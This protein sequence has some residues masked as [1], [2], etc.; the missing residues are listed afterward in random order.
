MTAHRIPR[1]DGRLGLC[2][3]SG[4]IKPILFYDH[5]R[6]FLPEFIAASVQKFG[7]SGEFDGKWVGSLPSPSL[8]SLTPIGIVCLPPFHTDSVAGSSSLAT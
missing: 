8:L 1:L 5:A 3:A 2:L 4:V 7:L 6:S